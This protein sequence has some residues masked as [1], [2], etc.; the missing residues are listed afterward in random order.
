VA[1]SLHTVV[2]WGI[3]ETT[4]RSGHSSIGPVGLTPLLLGVSLFFLVVT[5]ASTAV[6]WR[7][8]RRLSQA[9]GLEGLPE[10]RRTRARMMSVVGLVMNVFCL[11]MVG[12]G[13]VDV[14]VFPACQGTV[15][16]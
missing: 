12:F 16:L 15:A 13:V 1:W 3:D 5:A 6:S 2:D 14:L 10:L 7:H 9:E 4:C 11:M 8:W